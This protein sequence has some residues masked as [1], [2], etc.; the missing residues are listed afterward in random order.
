MSGESGDLERLRL[1]ES[2]NEALKQQVTSLLKEKDA[3]QTGADVNP[4][5]LQEAI[6]AKNDAL[7]EIE[8]IKLQAK[9]ALANTKAKCEEEKAALQSQLDALKHSFPTQVEHSTNPEL[10]NGALSA[11]GPNAVPNAKIQELESALKQANSELQASKE[12]LA[13]VKLQA[14]THIDGLKVRHAEATAAAAAAAAER[15]AA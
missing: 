14:R 8:K 4:N 5:R 10:S 3:P 1:L 9:K 12:E 15:E 6:K 11:N 7:A 2:E 13:K